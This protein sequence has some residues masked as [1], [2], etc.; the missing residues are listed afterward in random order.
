MRSANVG[1]S[2]HAPFRIV[3]E[4]GQVS[5]NDVESSISESWRVFHEHESRSNFANDSRHL[6]PEARA[7]AADS[8]ALSCCADVLTREAARDDVDEA[9]PRDAVECPD[10][11]PDWERLE[12]HVVANCT[13]SEHPAREDASSSARE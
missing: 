11:V 5:E 3:P 9:L 7:F 13:P 4:R 8:C 12:A 2:K 1:R 10:V 6:S